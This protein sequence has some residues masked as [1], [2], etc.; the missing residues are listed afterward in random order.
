MSARG[1]TAKISSSRSMSPPAL[2]SRV[3]TLTFILAFLA[4]VGVRGRLRAVLSRLGLLIFCGLGRVGRISLRSSFGFRLGGSAGFLLG[5]DRRDFLVARQRWDLVDRGIV[6]QAG[7][8][9][10]ELLNLAAFEDRGRIR[11]GL[12]AGQ[13]HGVADGQPG[14]LVAGHRA[15][16]EQQAADRVRTD[17]L[18]VL[19]GAIAGAHVAR[20][21]LV[22]KHA[23]R[24]LAVAGRAVRAVRDRDAVGR[25]ETAETPALHGAGKA[26]A[27]GHARHVDELARDEMVRR[28]VRA[29]VEQRIVGDAEL[30][31]T[32]LGL[33]F[34]LAESGTLRLGNVLRLGR[35]CAEL[36]GGVAVTVSFA[37]ADDLKLVQLQHGNRHMPTV[38][39]E[40]AG[41][42]DLLRDHAG[43][44]DQTPPQRHPAHPGACSPSKCLRAPPGL[45]LLKK[46]AAG[47]Q[48]GANLR[49]YHPISAGPWARAGRLSQFDLNVDAGSEIELH[50]R[51]HRLRR[52]LHDVEQ[53]LVGP[54]LELLARLLVDVRRTVDGEL[55]DTRRKGNGTANE[56]TRAARRIGDVA[57]RLVEHS[58][59]ERLQANPDILRFHVPT[60]AKEPANPSRSRGALNLTKTQKRTARP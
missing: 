12:V 58:M 48:P 24:I 22:L 38:R 59:I 9:N 7:L 30:G 19:L 37:A 56:S 60:D 6:D 14:A 11:R 34:S 17:D 16:D 55:L 43:A 2:A 28:D 42:S 45:V 25:A 44:H 57:S 18:E 41:H 15:L 39:L 47:T 32:R 54:H 10:L 40:Q 29:N 3:C 5:S 4:F 51:V 31:D 27:L 13:L 20:H 8:R 23:A 52:G 53:P 49:R 36:D 50:Q 46:G 33:D 21:L 35:S 26:L 1:S